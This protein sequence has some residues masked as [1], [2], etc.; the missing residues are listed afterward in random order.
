M[1]KCVYT[2]IYGRNR[3]NCPG[4]HWAG[5][6]LPSRV[7]PTLERAASEEGQSVGQLRELFADEHSSWH[8]MWTFGAHLRERAFILE[9]EI[10][11]SP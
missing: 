9:L 2:I 6:S 5:Y 7:Y 3:I 1:P 8:R 11:E 4:I 10:D